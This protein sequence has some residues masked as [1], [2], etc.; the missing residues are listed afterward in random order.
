MSLPRAVCGLRVGEGSKW[1]LEGKGGRKQ[2]AASLCFKFGVVRWAE[3][4]RKDT[5]GR[6]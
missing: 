5:G 1:L 4:I 6:V 3:T 2:A